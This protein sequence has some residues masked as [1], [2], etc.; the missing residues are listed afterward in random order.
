MNK[1]DPQKID[2][3]I[4]S[5]LENK[6]VFT[7]WEDITEEEHIAVIEELMNRGWEIN[8]IYEKDKE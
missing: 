8:D 7:I 3:I 1:I 5:I 6:G 4:K 2:E